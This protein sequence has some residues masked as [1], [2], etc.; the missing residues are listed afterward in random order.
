L[1]KE[2]IGEIPCDDRFPYRWTKFYPME[3]RGFVKV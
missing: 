1:L 3:I 2:A